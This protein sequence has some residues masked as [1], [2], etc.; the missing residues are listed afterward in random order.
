[1]AEFTAIV[2]H[3]RL[4]SVLMLLFQGELNVTL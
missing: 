3:H 1:M 4:R 2:F